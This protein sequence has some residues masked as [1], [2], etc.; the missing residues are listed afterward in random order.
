MC[1]VYRDA[2]V[3]T[4]SGSSI[5]TARKMSVLETEDGVLETVRLELTD[6]SKFEMPTLVTERAP[7][8]AVST[9]LAVIELTVATDLDAHLVEGGPVTGNLRTAGVRNLGMVLA[10]LCLDP[11]LAATTTLSVL[12]PSP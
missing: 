6:E 11:S 12:R 2:L 3:A 10:A 5:D 9:M 8:I 7:V 1:A 4:G